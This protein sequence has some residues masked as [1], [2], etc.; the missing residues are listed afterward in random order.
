MAKPQKHYAKWEKPNTKDHIIYDTIYKKFLEETFRETESVSVVAQ[1][2]ELEWVIDHKWL[3]FAGNENV[4][5]LGQGDDC[6]T[7]EIY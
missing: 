6:I 4:L 5:K 1:G 2:W 3:S 7:V